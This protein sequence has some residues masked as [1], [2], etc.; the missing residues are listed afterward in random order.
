[1]CVHI[2][3]SWLLIV[4]LTFRT[5]TNERRR[6]GQIIFSGCRRIALPKSKG[7]AF[8]ILAHR[9]I[10]HLR[11]GRFGHADFSTELRNFISELVH[12][13]DADVVDDWL[14]RIFMSLTSAGT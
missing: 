12:G 2:T 10:T 1:L 11:H 4:L 9:K 6:L 8:G 3:F 7:V 13:I 14:L 5:T